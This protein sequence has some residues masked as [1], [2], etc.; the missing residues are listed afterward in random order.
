MSIV[1]SSIAK[2]VNRNI[3]LDNLIKLIEYG[4]GLYRYPNNM[5]GRNLSQDLE[6]NADIL[7]IAAHPDDEVLG[8]GTTLHR[9]RKNGDNVAVTYV[10]NGAGG[11]G[12]TWKFKTEVT[13][14]IAAIRYKEGV[15]ALSLINIPRKNVFCL[16]YPDLGMHRYIK[17]IATDVHMLI[18]K[19]NPQKIY[20]HC[21]EGGHGDHDMTSFIV[22][23][24]C[25]K[26][27]FHNVFEWAEYNKRQ[28]IGTKEINF[29]YSRTT[30]SK[31]T[32]INIS[33][34]ERSLKKRMLAYH[35]SQGVVEHYMMGEAI[36]QANVS[37]LE[38]ELF[39][40]SRYPKERLKPVVNKIG[41]VL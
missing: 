7:V 40:Y 17:D 1:K 21:I 29:K 39:E 14:N 13:K 16:G 9:H 38:K 35:E 18:E 8:V 4:R 2:L 37:D 10:T 20:V 23:S 36:R 15:Q 28:V 22:K 6:D 3:G 19:L 33:N 41:S 30:N 32:I 27:G 24:V 31:E 25:S 26:L 5:I 34:E 11:K 12:S